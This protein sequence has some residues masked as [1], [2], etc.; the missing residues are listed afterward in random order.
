MAAYF[1]DSSALVKRYARETG[2]TWTLGLFRPSA[3]HIFYA[4]RITRVET[5]SALVRKRRGLHLTSTATTR[6]LARVRRDFGQRIV[7]VE[8]TP[9]LLQSAEALAES[10]HLRGYD[11]VQLAAALEANTERA[12]LRLTPLTMI[13]ADGALLAAATAEGLSTDNPENH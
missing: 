6:A 13:A 10:H 1:L 12:G 4:V 8:V 3:G 5:I 2:T 9:A 11:A 7:V